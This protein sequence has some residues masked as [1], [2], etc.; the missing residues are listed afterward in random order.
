[1]K[2]DN[3]KLENFRSYRL[4]TTIDHLVE[5]NVIIGQNNAGKSNLLK[6]LMWYRNMFSHGTT[7]NTDVRHTNNRQ[8]P[9][10]LDVEFILTEVER[11]E[12]LR[13]TG[14][15]EEAVSEI[16]EST[17]SACKSRHYVS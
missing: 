17:P 10:I 9:L 13:L 15:T 5:I 7:Y 6:A 3:V 8:K 16:M 12:I 11:K 4:P 14:K 2:L 1:M